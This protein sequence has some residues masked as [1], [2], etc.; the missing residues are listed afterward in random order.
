M[1]EG[2]EAARKDKEHIDHAIELLRAAIAELRMADEEH[3][4]PGAAGF[5]VAVQRR[6]RR[7]TEPLAQAADQEFRRTSAWH[8]R[9]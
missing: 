4:H 6:R 9:R 7:Q 1:P 2:D 8:W 5:I 3:P